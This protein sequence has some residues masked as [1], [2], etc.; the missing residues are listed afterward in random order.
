M[1]IKVLTVEVLKYR[2]IKAI[3]AGNHETRYIIESCKSEFYYYNFCKAIEL[4]Q[5][6]GKV[7]YKEGLGYYLA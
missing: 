2:I 3:K 1:K 5:S 7:L 4:L 6:E